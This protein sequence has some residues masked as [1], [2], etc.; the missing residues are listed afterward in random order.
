MEMIPHLNV[1]S[2][3]KTRAVYLIFC[4]ISI[5]VLSLVGW[6]FDINWLKHPSPDFVAM[7]PLTAIC[8]IFFGLALYLFWRKPFPFYKI[9]SFTLTLFIFISAVLKLIYLFGWFEFQIDILFF[10][11]EMNKDIVKGFVNRMAPNTA[12]C[13]FLTGLTVM[14]MHSNADLGN[15]H[16][17]QVGAVM[18]LLISIFSLLGYLFGVHALY[19]MVSYIP[20]ALQSAVCFLFVSLAILFLEP[21]KGI[22]KQITSV[23]TGSYLA[24][25]LLPAAI[26]VPT[27]IAF[28]R[29]WGQRQGFYDLEFGTVLLITSLII[30]FF[31]LILYNTVLLNKR[32]VQQIESDKQ[33]T[34][35]AN[36]VQQT[37]DAILSTDAG[38]H[39]QSWNK[40]AENIYGFTLEEVKGKIISDFLK[41]ELSSA[42]VDQSFAELNEKGFFRDEYIF[43]HKTRKKIY[44][45]ASV[46][47]LRDESGVI[48]GYVA[49]H[50][51]ITEQKKLEK[52]LQLLNENLELQVKE[53]TVELRHIFERI[54]DAFIGINNN[55][56]FVY[57]NKKA[58]K[59]FQFNEGDFS[60]KSLFTLFPD[61]NDVFISA[62]QNASR[63]Q[64]YVYVEMQGS[65]F[66]KWFEVHI[67]PSATGVS[68]YFRDISERKKAEEDLHQSYEQIR[69]LSA[70]I[71][72]IREEDRTTIAREIHDDLGQ[73]LTVMKMDV[74]WLNKR[75]SQTGDA[76]MKQK[77]TELLNMID[78][79]VQSIRRIATDLR[80]SILDD[81]GL[82]SAIEWNLNVFEKKSGVTTSFKHSITEIQL[83]NAVNTAV[84]RIFQEALTNISRHANATFVQVALEQENNSFTLH[85]KDNGGGFNSNDQINRATWGLLGM[86]E[87]ASMING[88]FH[89]ESAVGNGTIVSVSFPV[90]S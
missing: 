73:Q 46:T 19:E 60:G 11:D 62:V 58:E 79:V 17:T 76:A 9:V 32:D 75:I 37:S 63:T 15:T 78:G 1:Q 74:S 69:Q 61:T 41:S 40:A 86:K 21:A 36:L 48:N 28:L 87:R 16:L 43:Y 25:R 68:I 57:V 26:L 29:L 80:P 23:H 31:V 39:I 53:K 82:I 67:Y 2:K 8:F 6:A 34:Y 88:S 3:L 54:S 64:E 20:M 10:A 18:I 83:T 50:R 70:H 7:N 71:Q 44:V 65:L 5:G 45:Q 4:I 42:E 84:F 27:A 55:L 59:I 35:L 81:L 14:L 72:D 77:T 33:T 51:D 12:W 90:N 24:R 30:S 13:F 85:I 66:V 52:E 56:E 38:L 89:I 22:M 49:V 47:A